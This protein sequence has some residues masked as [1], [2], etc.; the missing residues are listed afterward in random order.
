MTSVRLVSAMVICV[1]FGVVLAITVAHER[2]RHA[3]SAP[4]SPDWR[5]A[6]GNG[7]VEASVMVGAVALT[8]LAIFLR[9]V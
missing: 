4:P 6:L 3:R 8:A 2:R 1:T 7:L 9:N 5:G